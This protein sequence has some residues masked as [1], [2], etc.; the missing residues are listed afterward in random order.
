[1]WYIARG[2]VEAIVDVITRRN[3][4]WKKTVRYRKEDAGEK[5]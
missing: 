2:F 4:E 5:L 1:M 3:A